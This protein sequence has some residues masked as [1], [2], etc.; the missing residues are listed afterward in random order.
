MINHNPTERVV[1]IL[2]TISESKDGCTLTEIC[3]KTKISKGTA[4]PIL[5]TLVN[6][7]MVLKN[8]KTNIYTIGIESFK[9]GYSFFKNINIYE[10]IKDTMNEIV[11]EVSEICQLGIF[12]DGKVFYISKVEPYRAIKL[13]SS[14]GQSLPAYASAL[15]KCLLSQL[16]NSEIEKM[17][18]KGLKP[19][20]PNTITDINILLKQIDEVR[21]N[22]IATEYGESSVEIE[23]IATPL[24]DKNGNIFAAMSVSI[25]RYRSSPKQ[26]KKIERILFEKKKK[27]EDFINFSNINMEFLNTNNF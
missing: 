24:V 15:G 18:E 6:L 23:C 1:F 7:K 16:T 10:L 2:N 19:L 8:P 4:F 22:K 11:Y 12:K 27:L 25:P 9:I 14:I 5:S 26:M 21:K 17:Y 20:T 13:M 3:E